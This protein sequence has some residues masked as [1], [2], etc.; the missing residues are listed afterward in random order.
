MLDSQF[1]KWWA[2]YRYLCYIRFP[3]RALMIDQV[4]RAAGRG[5]PSVGVAD[6]AMEN[7]RG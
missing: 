1:P 4:K 3:W 2:W 6:A 5:G 7:E